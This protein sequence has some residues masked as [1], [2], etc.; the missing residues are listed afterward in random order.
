VVR[1]ADVLGWPAAG[2]PEDGSAGLA[3][4]VT[5]PEGPVLLLVDE[6][7]QEREIVVRATPSRLAGL[8]LLLGTAQLDDGSVVLVL[9]PS[10]CVRAG[11][12]A[13]P[14]GA[15]QQGSGPAVA[16]TVLLVEDTLTTRELERGILETAGY[17]VLVATDG[18]RAWELLQERSVDAVVSDVAMPRMDGLA[19]CRAI[20]A[21]SRL[22][23][24]P[25]VL[26]TS[27]ASEEDRRG[28]L[29][30]GA[31]AYLTKQGFDREEL[32][33]TLERLL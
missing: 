31:D 24:L 13:G 19:L 1:L 4:V 5:D 2:P 26:V 21:S 22:G 23:D 16:P 11:R 12:A 20:R 32:L 27:L 9:S 3:L 15:G 28:G 8:G 18:V 33:H 14:G 25:V 30:A 6:V 17:T 7:A 29:E 10:A